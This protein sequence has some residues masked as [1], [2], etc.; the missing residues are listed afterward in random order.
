V[1]RR[2]HTRPAL[3]AAASFLAFSAL[4]SSA[5]STPEPTVPEA[6][7]IAAPATWPRPLP[8][9]PEPTSPQ[10]PSPLP[11]SPQ[12]SSSQPT[13]GTPTAEPSSTSP[14]PTPSRAVDAFGLV[15]PGSALPDDATCADG[16]TPAVETHPGNEPYNSRPGGSTL[17]RTFF[18]AGSHDPRAT[19]DIATRVTGAFTGTTPEILQ[20]VA[21][22]WGVDEAI[23]RAQA[24]AESSW[25]QTMMGDWTADPR[26]CAPGHGI[27]V[28]GRP[29]YCPESW[30]ILQVRYRFF[31]GAFPDAIRSTA[32]NA[33]AA[34]AVWRACY[35]GYEWWLADFAAPGH[36]YAAGDAWG[37]LGR[38]YSGQ[39]HDP[40]AERYID[41]VQRIVYGRPP[42]D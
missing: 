18:D 4:G 30:G 1:K 12:P 8:R 31:R 3:V 42:C 38:W 26:Y 20:W 7:T 35:E 16:V 36:A 32:F 5:G 10:P 6:F 14:E 27:G 39:W 22:K 28:D 29:G 34:Y 21:C 13:S 24:Q 37:C 17:P 15:P 23:V 41:C 33:D 11:S 19:T 25:R 9:S 40:L 2:T